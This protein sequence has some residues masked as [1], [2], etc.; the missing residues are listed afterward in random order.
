MESKD[1]SGQP[2]QDDQPQVFAVCQQGSQWGLTRRGFV[3]ASAG[4][5]GATLAGCG[6][7]PE[8]AADT[9]HTEA[10]TCVAVSPDEQHLVTGSK[11]QSIKLWN[12]P[13]GQLNKALGGHGGSVQ[14][15]AFSVDGK[16]L[17]SADE[18]GGIKLWSFPEGDE[19]QSCTG[20]SGAVQALYFSS[21]GRRLF[22]RAGQTISAFTLPSLAHEFSVTE[23]AFEKHAFARDSDATYS[24]CSS[25]NETLA[26]RKLAPSA[27]PVSLSAGGPVTA[28]AASPSDPVVALVVGGRKLVVLAMP[29]GSVRA[30][31]EASDPIDSLQFATGTRIELLCGRKLLSYDLVPNWRPAR[32]VDAH[33]DAVLCLDKS[34]SGDHVASC[35]RDGA[36][37][38]WQV[39]DWTSVYELGPAEK[40]ANLAL[41]P[42]GRL[43]AAGLPDGKLSVGTVAGRKQQQTVDAHQDMPTAM[44]YH[45]DG[46]EL[47]SVGAE[48]S[49]R[50]W[51]VLGDRL[52]PRWQFRNSNPP[53]RSP[54]LHA[55]NNILALGCADGLIRLW[56]CQSWN[57]RGTLAG[58]SG[59]VLSVVIDDR[60]ERLVS[61]GEDS[62]V[63]IWNIVQPT[64][65][66][67][68]QMHSGPVHAVD[69]DVQRGRLASGGQ[70]RKIC[71]S[72]FPQGA[73]PDVLDASSP[74][75][76]LCLLANGL[77]VAGCG[78]GKIRVW[79]SPVLKK[80]GE[81]EI[82]V[83][84]E[85]E[86]HE[87]IVVYRYRYYVVR[88]SK[89]VAIRSVQS[90]GGKTQKRLTDVVA[91]TPSTPGR[92]GR[93]APSTYSPTYSYSPTYAPRTSHYWRPN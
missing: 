71:L 30:W 19:K 42:D 53:V 93:V 27:A 49:V 7:K 88:Q 77:L 26:I 44:A 18:G 80:S 58:H 16:L 43:L 84:A 28:M 10:V 51:K 22:G 54:S 13:D 36:A 45:Q 47:V 52:F 69:I 31:A 37:K 5:A 67:K 62:T 68:L 32:V 6:K 64:E 11:D 89:T 74:V 91:S 82:E 73:L 65:E 75:H 66:R 60:G 21:D 8:P 50:S 39:S 38:V 92:T 15:L 85:D 1:A 3:T 61:A 83:E 33:R 20:D 72:S 25:A 79:E 17:A 78:D 24:V 35:G 87:L 4:V 40:I 56:D 57:S 55:R 70:D 23:A 90:S 86:K 34:S 46:A 12:L 9:A 48:G 2:S 29:G 76:D 14:A 41:S 59:G 81:I 63:R